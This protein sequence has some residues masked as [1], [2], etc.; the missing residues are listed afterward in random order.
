MSGDEKKPAAT[1]SNPDPDLIPRGTLSPLGVRDLPPSIRLRKMLG[2]GV[3]LAGLALGSGEFILWPYIT[4]ESKFIFFWAC[5]LG[6]TTQYFLN[7]EITRWTLATGESAITGFAR[8]SRLW[9]WVFLFLNVVPWLIPAWA[10]GGA[11][12]LSWLLFGAETDGAAGA[13]STV[14]LLTI[15]MLW[16]CGAVLT[17]GKVVYE[18][19]ERV[20][21]ILVSAAM[22]LVV[23]LAVILLRPDSLVAQARGAISFGSMPE[24]TEQLTAAV[25]LGAIAF[26]GVGGT[27][28]LGQSNYVKDKGYGMGRYIGRITSPITGQKETVSEIG[29]T[30]PITPENLNRWRRWWRTA[31]Q[32]HFLTFYL[33]CL[34]GLVLLTQI[35]YCLFYEPDGSPRP[36]RGNYVQGIGFVWG[37]AVYLGQFVGPAAKVLFLAMGVVILLTTEFGVLDAASRISSDI[38]KVNWLRN[39]PRWSESRLYFTFLWGTILLSTILLLVGTH[40]LSAFTLFKYTAAMNGGVMFLY[41]TLLLYVNRTKLPKEIRMGW[42]RVIMMVW[43]VVFFAFFSTWTLV[44]HLTS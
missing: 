17:A 42:P 6:V 27:L 11:Q 25:L 15:V 22:I 14:N 39:R 7:M 13:S 10:K 41:S 35:S 8:L 44:H 36:E 43:A 23:V 38:V 30:F 12:I 9:A 29:F 31:S 26:A 1:K 4:Y 33:T 28:N 5:L 40:H 34:V 3:I 21:I 20:Q 2:P 24:F 19:V 37:Q 16:A 18:T 32:E